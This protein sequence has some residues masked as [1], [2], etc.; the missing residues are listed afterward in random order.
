MKYVSKPPLI[1]ADS[2]RLPPQH[3]GHTSNY[4]DFI[5]GQKRR[6]A[7]RDEK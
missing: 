5:E 1:P 4:K 6:A 2:D 7:E 3:K